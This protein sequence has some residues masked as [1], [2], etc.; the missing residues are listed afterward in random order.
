MWWNRAKTILMPPKAS[1]VA[2]EVIGGAVDGLGEVADYFKVDPVPPV[3]REIRGYTWGKVKLDVV[4]AAMIAI[5][6]IPQAIAFALVVGVPI[7]AMLISAIIGTFFFAMWSSSRHVVFGPTNTIAV[8]MAGA[9]A[10]SVAAGDGLNPLQVVV[11]IGLMMG[12]I[13]LAAGFFKLGNLTHFI[14]RT[15]LIAY[16]TGAG[17]LIGVGQLSNFMGLS[18]PADVSL[19]GVLMHVAAG[20]TDYQVDGPALF[21]GSVT[22]LG[23]AFLKKYRERWPEGL[24][25]MVFTGLVALGYEWV[26]ATF[27]GGR[28]PE[29]RLVGDVGEV[30]GGMPVFSGFQVSETLAFIP[31]GASIALAAAILG[32]LETISISKSIAARSGQKINPNQELMAGGMA[33][34]FCSAFSGHPSSASFV[35]SAVAYESGG[36]SQVAVILSAVGVLGIVLVT[37]VLVNYIPLAALAAYVIYIALRLVNPAASFVV[38]RATR[39]DATVFWVTL[40]ATLFL[41]LDTAVYVGIGVSLALFLKKASAPSLV[42]YGF[43]QEGQLSQLDEKRERRNSAISIVHVEGELFFGAAD[44]FQEQVRYLADEDDIKVVVLRMKNAR[45]LDATSVMSLVQL[46]EYLHKTGRH[47]LVSGINPDVERVLKRSGAWEKLGGADNIFP[48]E[49][50]LTM[51]TKRA[52]LRASQLIQQDGGTGKAEVRIFYDRKKEEGKAGAEG[53]ESRANE[54]DHDKPA[55][56]QI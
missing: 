18:R 19:P 34:L 21:I 20:L 53:G 33:N 14:S 39:S 35:R 43:N 11:L 32:M 55:D 6:T 2:G 24:I 40:M 23:I 3:L 16:S 51:S 28:W 15:V 25:M 52:L 9:V 10:A 5:V 31:Q 50:N 30:A 13:Q 22:L 36:Q 29:M 38:R 37:A 42:E 12:V 49:A 26:A 45:H 27:G 56:F 1:R 54:G 17:V 44:L 47:L 41:S 46:L 4:A 8:I 48:A 7:Q